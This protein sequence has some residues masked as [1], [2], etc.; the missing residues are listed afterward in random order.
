MNVS[1]WAD[2]IVFL[3]FVVVLVLILRALKESAHGPRDDE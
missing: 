2:L 3:G 1:G